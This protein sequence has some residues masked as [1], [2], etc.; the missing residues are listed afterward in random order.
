M[1]VDGGSLAD[2]NMSARSTTNHHI[3][4][5]I[6]IRAAATAAAAAGVEKDNNEGKVFLFSSFLFLLC[7]AP[8]TRL[9]LNEKGCRHVVKP[10]FSR[11]NWY[12]IK[13]V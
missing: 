9:K 5:E 11:N 8:H 4:G 7:D 12:M 10:L 3:E 2:T 6:E 13:N 1:R